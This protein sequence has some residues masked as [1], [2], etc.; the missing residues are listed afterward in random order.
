[1]IKIDVFNKIDDVSHIDTFEQQCKESVIIRTDVIKR[2]RCNA[3]RQILTKPKSLNDD[4]SLSSLS[5]RS[6][7]HCDYRAE[8]PNRRRAEASPA[9]KLTTTEWE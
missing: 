3:W 9:V 8:L 2:R 4:E 1:M 7:T 5:F 6:K